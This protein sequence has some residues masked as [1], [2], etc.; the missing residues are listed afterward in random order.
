MR[1]E[2]EIDNEI[3]H[4]NETSAPKTETATEIPTAENSENGNEDG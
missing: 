4:E 2:G 1:N 3:G